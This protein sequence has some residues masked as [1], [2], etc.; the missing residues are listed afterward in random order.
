MWK[1]LLACLRMIDLG[2]DSSSWSALV[3]ESCCLSAPGILSLD[4][5][6][7]LLSFSP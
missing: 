4:P 7:S 6:S 3:S 5:A 2:N 1:K